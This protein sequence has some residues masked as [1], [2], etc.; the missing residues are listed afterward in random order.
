MLSKRTIEIETE[1]EAIKRAMSSDEEA[2]ENEG[3]D[4]VG[5]EVAP[6]KMLKILK[7]SQKYMKRSTVELT[8]AL[9]GAAKS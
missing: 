2:D 6:K 8:K 9:E 7:R 4:D 1:I 3:K 5:A